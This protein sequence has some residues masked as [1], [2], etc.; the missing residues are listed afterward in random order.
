MKT[1]EADGPM[2][3]ERYKL[4][5]TYDIQRGMQERYYQF[6]MGQFVPTVQSLGLR[7]SGAWHTAYGEYPRR[8]MEFIA[9]DFETVEAAIQSEEWA[10]LEAN[11]HRLVINY[12][13]KVLLFRE[14]QFQF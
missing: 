4:I 11:L 3:E 13:R 14:G 12:R 7:F 6:I 5:L 9:D 1:P 2:E 10:A 8:L